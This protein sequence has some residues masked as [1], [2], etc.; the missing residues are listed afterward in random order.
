VRMFPRRSLLVLLTTLVAV[1]VVWVPT[2]SAAGPP[3]LVVTPSSKDFGTI[4]AN[5]TAAQRFQVRNNGGSS[6]S[7]LAVSITGSSAFTVTANSCTG[8]ALGKNKTCSVTVQYAPT[9][10]GSTDNG[11]VTVTGKKPLTSVSATLTGKSRAANSPPIA[12]ALSNSSVEEN[13]PAGTTVGTLTT[14]D[15]D[16]GDTHTY[17]LVVGTGDEDN[18]KFQILGSTLQTSQPLDFEADSSLSVRI[19]TS[20]GSNTYEQALTVTVVNANDPPS[21][22]ALSNSSVAENQPPGTTVGTLSTTDQD[23]G[24]THTYS[25]VVGTGDE[26][27]AKFQIS[28]STLRTSQ[29]LDFEAD[30]SLSVRVRADDDAGGSFERVFTITITDIADEG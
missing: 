18:A 28:G 17:S 19:R 4:D 21:D 16:A 10:A 6:T 11:S 1:V 8:K 22:I 9:S 2:G 23:A 3:S 29:P 26:D 7:E 20:D 24:A 13:Q 15:P 27:N 25:L 30:P 14:D 5:T 12:L